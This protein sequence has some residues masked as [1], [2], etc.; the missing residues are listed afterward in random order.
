MGST[1]HLNG[2]DPAIA[3]LQVEG[4]LAN[5]NPGLHFRGACMSLR[6]APS[7]LTGFGGQSRNALQT[8]GTAGPPAIIREH[9]DARTSACR[10]EAGYRASWSLF[11]SG[12]Y[13][14]HH[15]SRAVH[16]GCGGGYG[17]WFVLS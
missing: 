11:P 4:F 15:G 16:A 1:R 9:T 8:K 6:A 12:G 2:R 17:R 14:W 3:M 7:R 10:F 5:H 13:V